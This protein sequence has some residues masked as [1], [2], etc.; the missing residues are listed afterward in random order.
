MYHPAL[1]ILLVGFLFILAF[2]GL[3]YIRGQGLSGQLAA[4]ALMVTGV[5]AGVSWG[6]NL[7][8]SPLAFLIIL[9][10]ITMRS[11]ILLDMGNFFLNAGHIGPALSLYRLSLSLRPDAVTRCVAWINISVANIRKGSVEEAIT[12][13][14]E[15][16]DKHGSQLGLKNE[17]A[18]LFN[19]GMAYKK[20][21][22]RGRAL[23]CFNQAM[24]LFPDSVYAQKAQQALKELSKSRGSGK[25]SSTQ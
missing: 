12:L 1:V 20:A 13:L 25:G 14:E 9:Y 22:Q 15:V 6:L 10:F 4:E 24:E 8:V 23:K 11:R 2:G 18:C 19:L 7:T 17:V 21:G 3:G 5:F 16:L